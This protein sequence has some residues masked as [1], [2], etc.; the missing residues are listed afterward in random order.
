MKRYTLTF[1]IINSLLLS[2]VSAHADEFLCDYTTRISEADKYNS[3]GGSLK[4]SGYSNKAVASILRQ[5]RANFYLFNKADAE[6]ET[7]C[8]FHSKANRATMQR[9]LS[10]GNIPTYAKKIIVNDYPLIHVKV[11]RQHIDVKIIEDDYI[12]PVSSVK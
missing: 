3:S 1:L 8:A 7:D 5:D 9:F 2:V 10:A 4:S 6:D 12:A 11:Y